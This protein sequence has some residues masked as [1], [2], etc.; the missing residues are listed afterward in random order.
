[1]QAGSSSL[2]EREPWWNERKMSGVDGEKG[3]AVINRVRSGRR[4]ETMM[5]NGK[6]TISYVIVLR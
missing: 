6:H 2:C 3:G 1:M 5:S 4:E